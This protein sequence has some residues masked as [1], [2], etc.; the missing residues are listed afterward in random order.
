MRYGFGY[1]E[2]DQL[3]RVGDSGI[4]RRIIA[5]SRPHWKKMALAILLSFIVIGAGLALPYMVRIGIDRFIITSD[6]DQSARIDGLAR[7]ASLFIGVIISGFVANFCQVFILE[8]IGQTIMH[9]LRQQL[10]RHMLDLD[11]A[12]FNNNPGG[13]LVTRLTNDIQNMHEMFTSVIVTLFND[14]IQLAGIMVILYWMNWRLALILTLLVP[15]IIGN[16]LWFSRLAR[17][18]F[19]VIRTQLARINS[20]LQE[21]LSGIAVIQTFL[22]E[23]DTYRNFVELSRAYLEKNLYQ[24]KI[25]GIFMP[26]IELFSA[27]AI[28]SIIWYGGGSVIQ[29]QMTLGELSAFIAYMRL[30]FQPIRELS[31]KYSIV[32]SA[33]A[34]AERIFQ[35]LDTPA[36]LRSGVLRTKETADRGTVT[37]SHVS[38]SYDQGTP[39]LHDLSFTVEPGKTLAIVGATG[40]GKSTIVNLLERFYEPEQGEILLDGRDLRDLDSKWLRSRMGLV[41]QEVF[42]IPG[43]IKE[44]ILLDREIDDDRLADIIDRAQLTGL[45]KRLPQGEDTLIG[46]GGMGL[47]AG[48]KQLLAFARVLARDPEVLILDEA[49]SSVDSETEILI[50]RAIAST[51]SGRTSIVIAHRLSTIRKADTILVMEHGRI[52]EQGSHDELMINGGLYRRLHDLQLSGGVNGE[53]ANL[54]KPWD[55]NQKAP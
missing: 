13:K 5:Y 26:A 35:L 30:F 46:E 20:F 1:F 2:E 40:S 9:R 53:P 8:W 48:Q 32:Q 50:D 55:A 42:I 18:A 22:R 33:L 39:I 51:L 14:F 3:G 6:L 24:I 47:S 38:F 27:V 19:R 52:M 4:W 25:F 23:K 41:M 37:F 15:L 54:R 16:T 10:F 29:G 12:F 7:L 43:S 28:A 44:N 21:S 31:Q 11:L 45:I 17:D 36:D 34:S 49:T